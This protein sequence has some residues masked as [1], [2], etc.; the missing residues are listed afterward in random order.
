MSPQSGVTL[1]FSAVF[2]LVLGAGGGA[3]PPDG[4]PCPPD[5]AGPELSEEELLPLVGHYGHEDLLLDLHVELQ[6]GLFRVVIPLRTAAFPLLPV[7]EGLFCLEGAPG[8]PALRFSS[9][10]ERATVTLL[11]RSDSVELVRQGW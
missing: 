3:D 6:D 11:Q 10:G 9:Q 4:H 2:V 7:A 5:E 1:L 8:D